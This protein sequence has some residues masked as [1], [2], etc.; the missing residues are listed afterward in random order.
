MDFVLQK[1]PASFVDRLIDSWN[2]T[3]TTV[4]T[5]TT[6]VDKNVELVEI[7]EFL[8]KSLSL[9]NSKITA[10]A[11]KV[12]IDVTEDQKGE[13]LQE[14]PDI[15]ML[16]PRGRF[17]I[18][19]TTTCLMI[20][21]K[22]GS[23]MI[24]HEEIVNIALLPSHTSA[25]KEGEDYL[26]LTFDHPLKVCGKDSRH[27]L[28]NLS[29]TLPKGSESLKTE[30]TRFVEAIQAATEMKINQPN[31]NIFRSIANQKTPA[32][33]RCHKGTQEGAIYPLYCGIYFIK[34]TLFVHVDE[35][36]SI[37]AG[38]GGSSGNTRFVD[39]QV[40]SNMLYRR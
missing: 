9:I 10:E 15:Q 36:A 20:E 13:M 37:S 7:K 28:F 1:D 17:K 23:A 25:K 2:T 27:M 22:S 11:K 24:P 40:R 35:I 33:L 26:A 34:P 31:Q 8:S 16:E 21:G 32:F 19:V 14:F 3:T 6:P 29:K 30:S 38:R 4:P 39:L 12:V 18:Q 5:S